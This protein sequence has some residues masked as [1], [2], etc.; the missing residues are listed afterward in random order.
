M[1]LESPMKKGYSLKKA[2]LKKWIYQNHYTQPYIAKKLNLSVEEF[3]EKLTTHALF[4]K[5]QITT[6]IYLM[7]AYEAF[8]IIYF[9]TIEERKKVYQEVFYK[10][11]V[12]VMFTSDKK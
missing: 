7:G 10:K 9:P 8:Q 2:K 11:K 3:K 6:L 1:Q 12:K 5:D 4:S